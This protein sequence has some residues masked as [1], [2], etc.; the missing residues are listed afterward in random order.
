MSL[1]CAKH[2]VGRDVLDERRVG[3]HRSV[4]PA[5]EHRR[6]IESK[7]V[8]V[9]LDHPEA[10]AVEDQIANHRMVAVHG[11]AASGVVAIRARSR[12]HHVVGRVVDASKRR[13]RANHLA[14]AGVIE[15]QIENHLDAG[16]VELAH[17]VLEFPDL[18]AR[19]VVV[20]RTSFGCE[21]RQRMVAPHVAE[22]P[23]TESAGIQ[24]RVGLVELGDRHQ[25]HR[26][27][28]QRLE[29]RDLLRQPRERAGM[30]HARRRVA[31][32]SADV[33]FVDHRVGERNVQR[34][35]ESPVEIRVRDQR[36]P[37]AGAAAAPTSSPPTIARR[38]GRAGSASG[39][40]HGPVRGTVQPKSVFDPAAEAG[41]EGVPD[42]AG[43]VHSGIER[44]F[45]K[46][47]PAARLK[48]TSVTA[49]A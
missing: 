11:V 5:P 36:P 22:R 15:D 6:Q 48:S 40:T 18:A 12:I 27:D 29:I 16:G 24:R 20:R 39:R 1:V 3:Q 9:H 46:R 25:L 23:G 21:E 19:T 42:V 13:R 33:Q 10:E 34:L 30:P 28:A 43:P 45:V 32:E 31:R 47:R 35:I 2:R 8:D 49:S 37:S 14:F 44:Q 4:A 26:R 7:T 38:R 17:H 41:D